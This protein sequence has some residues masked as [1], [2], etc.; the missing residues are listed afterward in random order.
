MQ[1]RINYEKMLDHDIL[2]VMASEVN[3]ISQRQQD[4]IESLVSQQKD[5]MKLD[6]R[7]S[8]VETACKERHSQPS[9]SNKKKAGIFSGL[10]TGLGLV[11]YGLI[12]A[13]KNLKPS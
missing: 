11:I 6:V 2:V 1:D 5:I 3:T 8:K 13:L 4:I 12:E 9:M 7:L 10:V